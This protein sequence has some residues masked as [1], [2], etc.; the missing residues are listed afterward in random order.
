MDMLQSY[1]DMPQSCVDMP[2][3]CVDM[4]QS[5][6]DMLQS[7]VDMRQ[8]GRFLLN[9]HLWGQCPKRALQMVKKGHL[10]HY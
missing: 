3:S 7:C 1:V 5:C 8:S 2:Q 4:P 10:T 6:V 9:F